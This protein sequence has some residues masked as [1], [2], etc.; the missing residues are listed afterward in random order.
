MQS[1][2]VEA[3]IAERGFEIFRSCVERYGY[4][5]TCAVI[6]DNAAYD[7]RDMAE[8][9]AKADWKPELIYGVQLIESNFHQR[10]CAVDQIMPTGREQR[11]KAREAAS[12]DKMFRRAFKMR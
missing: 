10:T 1:P 12:F 5:R 4:Y 8:K 7:V 9:I 11:R 6:E 2:A 3:F